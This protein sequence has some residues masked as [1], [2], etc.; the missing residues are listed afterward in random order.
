LGFPPPSHRYLSQG[1]PA[2]ND[3][4]PGSQAVPAVFGEV[5]RKKHATGA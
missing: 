5:L 4:P 3:E 1:V 2:R